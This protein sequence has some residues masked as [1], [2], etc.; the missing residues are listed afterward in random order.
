MNKIMKGTFA[1]G[2]MLAAASC[3]SSSKSSTTTTAGSVAVTA[4]TGASTT[5][6]TAG[7][8]ADVS[9]LTPTQAQV[10]TMNLAD[11]ASAG[12]NLDPAC[13]KTAVAK[14]S[15][16][17]AK[18]IVAAGPGGTPTL[19]PAGEAIGKEAAACATASTSGTTPAT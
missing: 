18:L 5:G 15:E 12:V 2:L 19:S 17:D 11:A 1:L 4:T 8:A 16:A 3:G 6:T 9:G 10:Y 7:A 13:F 14:L